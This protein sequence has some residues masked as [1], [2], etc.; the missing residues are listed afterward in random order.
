MM[1]D[2]RLTDLM[3]YEFEYADTIMDDSFEHEYRVFVSKVGGGTVGKKYAG[4]WIVR[5]YNDHNEVIVQTADLH[6]GSFKRHADVAL[7]ALDMHL[8]N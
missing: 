4:D 2:Y 7:E 8:N 3:D 6:T 1:N 5:I